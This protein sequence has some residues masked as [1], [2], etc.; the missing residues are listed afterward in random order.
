MSDLKEKRFIRFR[1]LKEICGLSRT[2][3]WR[4]EKAG[5][6]PKSI[7]LSSRAS[8]WLSTEI[9]DWINSKMK[10]KSNV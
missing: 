2:S 4:L 6:F 8:A 5:L 1:E 10:E 7:K 3:L 9:E